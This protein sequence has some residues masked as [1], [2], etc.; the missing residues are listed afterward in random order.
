MMA[1]VRLVAASLK[2]SGDSDTQRAYGGWAKPL[3]GLVLATE[4]SHSVNKSQGLL[5]VRFGGG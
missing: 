4:K 5:T 1:N 3:W 2:I